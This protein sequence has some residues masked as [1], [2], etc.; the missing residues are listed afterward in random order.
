MK[1]LRNGHKIFIK[2]SQDDDK[3]FKN[4][5]ETFMKYLQNVYKMFCMYLLCF[6]FTM[7]SNISLLNTSLGNIV[8]AI[9]RGCVTTQRKRKQAGAE[10]GQAQ[11]KLG[12]GFT[13]VF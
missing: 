2:Y 5:F 1:L 7:R 3:M 13:L 6:I 12:L 9:R 4:V 10:L 8:V 11:L